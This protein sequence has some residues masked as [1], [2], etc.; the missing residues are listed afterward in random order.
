MHGEQNM[1][2]VVVRAKAFDVRNETQSLLRKLDIYEQ[3]MD[4]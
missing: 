2:F 1:K 4:D 3:L